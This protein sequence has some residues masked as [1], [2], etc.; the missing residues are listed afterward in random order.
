MLF[1]LTPWALP[2]PFFLLP[3]GILSAEQAYL[4]LESSPASG[5]LRFRARRMKLEV[6]F[7]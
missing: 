1:S 5:G 3:V 6:S 2:G 7:S 4:G